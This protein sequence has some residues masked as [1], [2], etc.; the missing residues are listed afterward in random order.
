MNRPFDSKHF[1][2]AARDGRLVGY[3]GYGSLVN[4]ATLR[5]QV[6]GAAPARLSGW[7]RFW[8][9]R[10][11]MGEATRGGPDAAH[12]ETTRPSAALLTAGPSA[13]ACI[14]GLLVFDLVE[15]LP[16][17]DRRE[18]LYHRRE[19]SMESF[20]FR[21]NAP[22]VD[23]PVYIYEAMADRPATAASP[24]ILR[25]YLDAVM[26][27]FLR[28]FGVEGVHRFVAE[29]DAFDTPIHEDRHAPV[30]PRPVELSVEEIELF[31]LSLERR[32]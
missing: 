9:P 26:Q 4:R 12:P 1:E 31:A 23:C 28:E 25:S 13:S 19:I 7:R 14:D 11:D 6:V 2:D 29:T 17:V 30:Y 18:R 24:S 5:T 15:N 27:G 20:S 16:A 3:F 32:R 10:P 8:R 22:G 21:D